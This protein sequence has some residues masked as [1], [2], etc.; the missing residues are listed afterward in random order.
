MTTLEPVTKPDLAGLY[1][2]DLRS[3][4][5]SLKHEKAKSGASE[6][7]FLFSVRNARGQMRP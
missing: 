1:I 2:A 5:R 3:E 7:L 4:M 6:E